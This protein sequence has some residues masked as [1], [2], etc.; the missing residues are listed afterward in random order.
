MLILNKDQ[1]FVQK[2]FLLGYFVVCV[3]GALG[4]F[5][6]IFLVATSAYADRLSSDLTNDNKID[7]DDARLVIGKWG[8]ADQLCDVNKDGTVN[9]AD[10]SMIVR[11]WGAIDRAPSTSNPGAKLPITYDLSTLSGTVRYVATNGDDSRTGASA[12]TVAAPFATIKKAES[13]SANGDTIVVRGGKY[14]AAQ[15][16]VSIDRSNLTI[17]AY[18]G[19][20]PIFD[21]AKDVSTTINTEGALKYFS[22]QP[23]PAGTGEGLSLANLPKATFS[24][25]TPTGMAAERGYFCVSGSNYSGPSPTTGNPVGCGTTSKIVNGS[26][27]ISQNPGYVITGYFPDQVWVNDTPL[28]QVLEKKFVTAGKFWLNRTSATDANPAA[29]NIYLSATD[30]VD[31]SKV[32]VSAS[33]G[34]FIKIVAPSVKLAGF[35]I[36]HNSP[37]WSQPTVSVN[38]NYA[39][40]ENIHLDS[41]ASGA[42]KISRG[43]TLATLAVGN[44]LSGITISRSGWT[45][46][47]FYYN[48]D[49]TVNS[50]L[51]SDNEIHQ[52]FFSSPQR[53]AIKITKSDRTRV[54]NSTF[55]NNSL[56]VWFDQ[57]NFKA[58]VA[59][60]RFIGNTDSAV[61]YE[62]SH[63]LTL[64]NNYING[65]ASTTGAT[66]RLAGSSGIKIVNNTIIGGKDALWMGQDGRSM[67]FTTSTGEKRDCSE[68]VVRY[69]QEGDALKDCW[70]SYTSD[71]DVARPGAYSPNGA[72]NMTPGMDWNNSFAMFVNNIVADSDGKSNCGSLVLMCVSGFISWNSSNGYIYHHADLKKIFPSTL[73]MNGNIYQVAS[74]KI[75]IVRADSAV[76]QPGAFSAADIE[77]LKGPSGFGSAFYGLSVESNSI[78]A[79]SGLV[80]SQGNISS[81]VNHGN[82]AAVPSDADVNKYIPVGTK[83][84]GV[85]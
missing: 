60:N 15:N 62:I 46:S 29:T 25:S 4:L 56:G 50:S 39:V 78:S 74:G 47:V 59:D 64:V 38:N 33:N 79:A 9:I 30:T 52:E 53:G 61:F 36:V 22:Y 66:I 51:Y 58:D 14:P 84:Y 10:L 20:I 7:M 65:K 41:N 54:L 5:V 55:E 3:A 77:T 49:T 32:K 37:M 27:V 12:G 6:I 67:K 83:H 1:G 69:G 13:V 57:S 19:E 45:G 72:A 31:M 80:D 2:K 76:S 70:V 24:G 23:M 28:V 43:N 17:I 48:D 63:G 75:A 8:T 34:S 21:G 68:H 85:Y 44:T 18:P 16:A 40:L 11:N 73:M 81:S 42:L 82:A 35:K 26:T 71:F